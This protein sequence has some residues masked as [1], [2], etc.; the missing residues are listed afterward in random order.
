MK[1]E[2]KKMIFEFMLDFNNEHIEKDTVWKF[3]SYIHT[4]NGQYSKDGKKIHD[5]IKLCINLIN[6]E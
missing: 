5:F 4:G 1:K 3:R 2:L 6:Y